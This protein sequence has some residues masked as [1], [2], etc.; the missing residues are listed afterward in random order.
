MRAHSRRSAAPRS[1][2][3]V[4][5]VLRVIADDE[6]PLRLHPG[7]APE[8]GFAD[9]LLAGLAAD[10]G[11]YVPRTWPALSTPPSSPTASA[12]ASHSSY[13]RTAVDVMWPFVPARSNGRPSSRSPPSRT[14]ASTTPMWRR[15]WPSTTGSG[16]WSCSGARPWPSRTSPCSSWGGCSTTNSPGAGAGHDRGRHLRRHRLGGHRGLPRPGRPRHLR[17]APAGTRHRGAAPPDDHGA[18][19]QRAQRGRGGQLRRLPGSGEGHVRRRGLPPPTPPG[20]GHS[21]NFA[22]V[23]AQIVYY[24]VAA[25]ALGGADAGR[26]WRSPCQRQLRQRVR[27]LCG[28]PHGSGDPAAGRG[29][30]PQRHPGP[31]HGVGPPGDPRGDPHHVAQHGHPGVLQPGAAAL[32][33]ARPRRRRHRLPGGGPARHRRGRTRA[34]PAAGLHPLWSGG[35]VDEEGTLAIIGDVYRAPAG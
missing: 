21:I 19:R 10:G 8:L 4:G 16:S 30:Q 31:L 11:L 28:T 9:V 2:S 17:V 7:R 27:R 33:V 23:M 32:R 29:Q 6:P 3:S 12:P 22:R 5:S 1:G 20:G 35:R 15:S 26:R 34:G 25:Q 24:V 18:V 14:R 13:A